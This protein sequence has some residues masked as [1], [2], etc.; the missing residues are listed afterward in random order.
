VA[1]EHFQNVVVGSG[2][3]GKFIDWTLARLGQPTVTRGGIRENSVALR[4]ASEFWRI[5]LPFAR[6][7]FKNLVFATQ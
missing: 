4:V 1:I 7:C 3:A 5:Q 2:E 6:T